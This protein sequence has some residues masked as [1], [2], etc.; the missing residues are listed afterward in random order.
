VTNG[1]SL[2]SDRLL[3]GSV[4]ESV[5]TQ[6]EPGRW[7]RKQGAT[8]CRGCSRDEAS[9]LQDRCAQSIWALL[10]GSLK[11]AVTPVL[12]RPRDCNPRPASDSPVPLRLIDAHIMSRRRLPS[13]KTWCRGEYSRLGH[14][15][16]QREGGDG[17]SYRSNVCQVLGMLCE[18]KV[19][20]GRW[21]RV[22]D[23]V[24]DLGEIK[25]SPAR[26]FLG[27]S[28]SSQFRHRGAVVAA[29]EVWCCAGS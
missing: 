23:I 19:A 11:R 27:P 21:W 28:A 3:S 2:A 10:V 20:L 6:P 5:S 16:I 13:C 12:E 4:G 14:S 25:R 8:P 18:G 24:D 26:T 9:D 1:A 22:A 29:V 15:S 17:A 7:W